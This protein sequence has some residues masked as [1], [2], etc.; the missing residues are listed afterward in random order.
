VSVP[1]LVLAI[2]FAGMGVRSAVWWLRRPFETA[3]VRDNLLFAAYLTGRVGLWFA[4]SGFFL[5]IAVDR[6]TQLAVGDAS[7]GG[8]ADGA[9][10]YRWFALVFL[11]LAAIK[12]VATHFLANRLPR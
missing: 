6:S 3:D 1:E 9:Y 11:V 7:G 12:F 5:L 8:F 2:V 10:H 4:V